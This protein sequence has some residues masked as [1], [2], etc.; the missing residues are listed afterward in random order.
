M[1]TMQYKGF[2]GSIEISKEDKILY[3]K[4]LH[5]NGLIT[6]EAENYSELETA[7]HDAVDDYLADCEESGIEP[8]K[9]CSGAFNIRVKPEKHR[10]LLFISSVQN[11]KLNALVSEG[12]DLVITKYATEHAKLEAYKVFKFNWEHNLEMRK[13]AINWTLEKMSKSQFVSR[14]GNNYENANP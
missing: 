13:N 12:V 6:Y 3:G 4:L 8:Q 14:E 2:L 11:I 10:Q 5:I 1:E 9:S 7:F